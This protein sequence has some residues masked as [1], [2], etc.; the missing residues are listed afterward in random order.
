[1]E[2]ESS[3]VIA[4][5]ERD[6]NSEL[7]FIKGIAP[8]EDAEQNEMGGASLSSPSFS[9]EYEVKRNAREGIENFKT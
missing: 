3:Q 2:S 6:L 9:V 1:M 7:D 4:N 8:C 5:S